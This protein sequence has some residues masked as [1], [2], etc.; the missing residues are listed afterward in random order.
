MLGP[1]S[2]TRLRIAMVL[3]LLPL[4]GGCLSSGPEL[5]AV[6]GTITYNGQPA[7]QGAVTFQPAPGQPEELQPA[8]G[9][10][11]PD[12]TYTMTSAHG[13]GIPPG[14]Y[15]VAIMS[16]ES[17]DLENPVQKWL[18]PQKYASPE[19]SGLTAD[20]SPSG[21]SSVTINFDLPK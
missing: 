5:V 10:I 7:T 13:E 14:K 8:T 9:A 17:V 15:R 1:G 11:N 6:S 2:A 3:G 20:L 16:M 18:V 12:G 4:L 21:P 19:T